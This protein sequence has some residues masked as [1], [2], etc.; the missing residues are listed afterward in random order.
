M[1][2]WLGDWI[3][4]NG[5]THL[6]IKLNGDNL[7][8]DVARV[9][10]IDKIAEQTQAG[11]GCKAWWYSLDFN[12]KCPNVGYVL[13]FLA[14]VKAGSPAG[15]DRIQYIE[16]PTHRNLADHPE[17]TMHQASAVRPVVIDESLVSLESL[18][19]SRQLGYT[20]IA[21][22]AC[23]GITESLLLAAVAQKEN[24]FRC[25][26]DLTC[27]GRSFL[28]SS[29]LA[30]RIPGVPAIEGNGRQYCPAGNVGWDARYPG[31]VPD[32]QRNTC[33]KLPDRVRFGL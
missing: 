20:G 18:L 5:L 4:F 31:N 14:Q 24:M 11:R 27:P 10:K 12:E 17:N 26:Q 32:Q 29:V 7:A 33:H 25:V 1:P 6:K 30:A 22:K 2:T 23:K 8:W 15:F 16:Q 13:E 3:R 28:A 9:L 19:L 21:L